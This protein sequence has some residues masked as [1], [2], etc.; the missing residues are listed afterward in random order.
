MS[1]GS[2]AVRGRTPAPRPDAGRHAPGTA[3]PAP[4]QG[5]PSPGRAGAAGGGAVPA[6]GEAAAE[7]PEG[8]GRTKHRREPLGA[9]R[10]RH[11][12]NVWL[13]AMVSS[14]GGWMEIIGVQW[15]VAETT[16]STLWMGWIAAAQLGPTLLLG[17]VGGLTADRVDRKRLLLA[18]QGVMMM[19]AALLAAAAYEG[20]ATPPVLVGLMLLHGTALAFNTPAWQVL[21]PRLVPREDL[22][23]AIALNGLQFNLARIVGP[24]LG[25]VL[26]AMY[27]P[28]ALFAINTLSF[29]VVMAAVATTPPSPAPPREG[30]SA[31]EQT[32]EALSFVFRNRGPRAVFL[33]MVVFA[34][35]AAPL[36]RMLPL[37][38]SEVYGAGEETYGLML[39]VMGAGA[40]AG[41]LLLKKLPTWYP[42]HHFIPASIAA[43]G[44]SIV[45]FSTAT[46]IYAAGAILVVA[47]LFWL[48]SF[49]SSF[50]AMQLLVEDRMRGRAM[51]VC[52]TAVFGAMPLGSLLAGI[53]GEVVAGDAESGLGAQVGVGGLGFALIAAGL[54]MLIWRTPEIDA[55]KP[56]EPGYER[57]PGLIAGITARA[58]RPR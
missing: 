4:E 3:A 11:F 10:H 44:I 39:G 31:W 1:D 33:G 50:A 47:G 51:A 17:L 32:R 43:S 19:I 30:L 26:M 45:G 58:H 29:L 16:G 53:I 36:M 57:R 21:T 7:G 42:M 18:T 41:V 20:W 15:I 28:T 52:N 35:L 34:M 5:P 25:G 6:E 27:G 46:N 14:I 54:T 55:I 48:W 13:A 9:L 56:G 37:F 38:V 40:V 49:N 22:T 23:E 2:H 24:A 8:P 12:R